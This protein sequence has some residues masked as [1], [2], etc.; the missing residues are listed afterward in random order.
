MPTRRTISLAGMQRG[1]AVQ[2]HNSIL[3]YVAMIVAVVLGAAPTVSAQC[4]RAEV[5][6]V[7]P[8][9]SAETRPVAYGKGTIHV[10]RAPLATLNDVVA[11]NFKGPEAI[12]L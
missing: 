3:K 4:P 8:T 7:M 10:S 2:P 6:E 5:V 12:V 1:E 9:A 11:V